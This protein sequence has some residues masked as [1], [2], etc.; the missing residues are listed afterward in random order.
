MPNTPFT[1]AVIR[2]VCL[3]LTLLTA[4]PGLAEPRP[5]AYGEVADHYERVRDALQAKQWSIALDALQQLAR[6]T[7]AV[8]DEAEYHNLSGFALRQHDTSKLGIAIEHYQRALRIDPSHVQAREYLGQAYLL[9][10]RADLAL[11][12]LRLIEQHCPGQTCSAWLSLRHAMDGGSPTTAP[13][14]S[15]R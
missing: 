3:C 13:S 6:E 2:H 9:Q 7:P 1:S 14:D 5:D 10:G 8:T 12:Q 15:R 11:Q 4:P